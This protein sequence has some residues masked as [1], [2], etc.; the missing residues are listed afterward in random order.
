MQV[1]VNEK[2]TDNYLEQIKATLHYIKYTVVY[3]VFNNK[4]YHPATL[5]NMHPIL[6]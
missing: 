6:V 4:K 1:M 5:L 2:L 3:K